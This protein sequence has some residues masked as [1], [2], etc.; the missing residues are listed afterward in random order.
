MPPRPIIARWSNAIPRADIVTPCWSIA[1]CSIFR[2]ASAA[3]AISDLKEAIALDPRQ[4]NAY[5]T[6][7]QVHRREHRL[8][9]ALERLGQAI[10]L[11]PDQPALYRMRARWTPGEARQDASGMRRRAGRPAGSHQARPTREPCAGRRSRR[12]RPGAAA[13]EAVSEALDACDASLRIDPDNAEVH[14]CRVVALLELKQYDE[15]VDACDSYLKAGHQVARSTRLA[16]IGQIQAQR[17]Y[18][19]DRGLHTGSRRPAGR[20]RAALAGAAGHTSSPGRYQLARRDFDEAIRL[21]PASGDAYGG[22]GSTLAALG[23]HREA[24]LD[25]EESLRHGD[26]EAHLVYT[27]AR[28]MAQAAQS[29]AKEPRPRGKPDLNAIRAYQDRAVKLLRQAIEQTPREAR[30]AFWRDVVEPDP[31]SQ[32]DPPTFRICTIG[33]EIRAASSLMPPVRT[34]GTS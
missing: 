8:D 7:A 29:A 20:F 26:I 3:E 11:N 16:W 33:R 22:R 5:V 28:T 12:D 18:R 2:A 27:A 6:L 10:A 30:A 17:F 32:R 1:A 31:A 34:E 23:D 15:A 4:V 21:D 14:R 25:A 13:A 24:V 19:C 9:L